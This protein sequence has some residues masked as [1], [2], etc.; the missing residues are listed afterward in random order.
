MVHVIF[1]KI[2]DHQQARLQRV[3]LLLAEIRP[4]VLLFEHL[5]TQRAP[6]SRRRKGRP[7]RREHREKQP[8]HG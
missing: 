5:E 7:A 1:F 2:G 3:G 6:G 8:H 4:V